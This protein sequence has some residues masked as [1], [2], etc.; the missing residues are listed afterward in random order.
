MND[1]DTGLD[2][3]PD[4]GAPVS[5]RAFL[6]TGAGVSLAATFGIGHA[7]ASA[8][9]IADA[10]AIAGH[11]ASTAR[12]T[13]AD[14]AGLRAKWS[15]M[16]TGK[17]NYNPIAAPYAA[18]ISA[19]DAEAR[20]WYSTLDTAPVPGGSLW[21]DTLAGTNEV[22]TRVSFDRLRILAIAYATDGSIYENDASLLSAIA[23]S[24]QWLS[25]YRYNTA[26]IKSGNWWE[27]EIGAPLSLLDTVVILHD[28]LSPALIDALM[29]AIDRFASD[30]TRQ[31]DDGATGDNGSTAEAANRV[32]KAQIVL[33]RAIVVEDAAKFNSGLSALG[34]TYGD[35]SSGDGFYADGSFIQHTGLAYT[36]GYGMS[37]LQRA[38]LALYLLD[39]SGQAPAMDSWATL[40]NRVYTAFEPT[41]YR[42]GMLDST[43]GRTI[44][45]RYAQDLAIGEQVAAAVALLAQ[46]SPP[47]DAAAFKSMVKYWIAAHTA[48]RSVFTYD[49]LSPISL[50]VIRLLQ[51]IK[52]DPG[53]AHR[54]ERPGNYQFQAMDRVVHKRP[55]F[56]FAIA[57]YSNF[58]ENY[59]SINGENLHGFYTGSGMTY[60]YND[61]TG[62]YQSDFWPTVDP[63]RLPGTTIDKRSL[64]DGAMHGQKGQSPVG[65]AAIGQ[66][67]VAGMYLNA[68]SGDLTCKK[69]WFMF[70]DCILCAGTG[71]TDVSTHA[72]ETIVENRNIGDASG[73]A[74]DV[75]FNSAANKAL[76]TPGVIETLSPASW[77]N[78]SGVG[79]YVFPPGANPTL[80]GLRE[81]RSG[82]WRAINNRASSPTD[83]RT[84]TYITLWFDHGA[85]PVRQ[86]YAYVLLPGATAAATASYAAAPAITLS[87][88]SDA[89]QYACGVFPDSTV[90]GAVFWN[91]ASYS[92]GLMTANT[93]VFALL[94]QTSTA[95][96]IAL[97]DPTEAR[98]A[99]I[100]VTVNIANSGVHAADPSITVTRT[101]TSATLTFDPT[102]AK[103]QSKTV[104]LK[105]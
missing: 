11:A 6:F 19:I 56:A 82:T 14:Y 103:G 54:G 26:I 67:G 21:S 13:A 28:S 77:I 79:G 36:G 27:W 86:T 97:A 45:R 92:S 87:E 78:I 10:R 3:G 9:A 102:G 15:V 68:Y 74:N 105:P 63:Y 71:I 2:T 22:N 41:L 50:D 47:A 16:Q 53:V 76:L 39:G 4:T 29:S 84:R 34:S 72:V 12:P 60:I 7:S 65:G 64:A 55:A 101:A 25:T 20:G 89:A 35:V 96:D 80:K 42:G 70:G 30:P 88:N 44:S 81:R 38:A 99:S 37:F 33:V 94:R 69:A 5:R 40:R 57:M 100:V 61:D 62:A 83:S 95:I 1:P 31:G 104:T 66:S 49:P 58:I 91:D 98:T 46:I 24:L 73:G 90:H 75:A 85:A 23:A 17:G 93:S 18:Y 52:T 51:A 8:L 48:T 43:M 59:E 32:W